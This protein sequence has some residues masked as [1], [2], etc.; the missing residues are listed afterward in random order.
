M[1]W[2]WLLRQVQ[3]L[4]L[5]L[6]SQMNKQLSPKKISIDLNFL[7]FLIMLLVITSPGLMVVV[8]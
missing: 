5:W 4:L 7:T 8:V 1:S 6:L 3:E 2:V